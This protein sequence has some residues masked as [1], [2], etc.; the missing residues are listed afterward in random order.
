MRDLRYRLHELASRQ[1]PE[2][3]FQSQGTRRSL[4]EVVDGVWRRSDS[5]R[6]Y[7]TERRFGGGYVH[8]GRRVDGLLRG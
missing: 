1:W 6:C 2:P 8:G 4:E 5:G 3:P 7:V